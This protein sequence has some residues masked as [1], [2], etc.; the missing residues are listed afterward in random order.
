MQSVLDT[1][2]NYRDD[3]SVKSYETYAYHPITGTKLDNPGQIVIRIENQDAFFLP[4][5]SWLQVEW[6]L[7]TTAGAAYVAGTLISLT[8]NGLMFLFDNIKYE[9][10]EQEI[11]SIYATTMLRMA[12]Y[13][14]NNLN[15]CWVLDT[16][17]TS[18][19]ANLGFKSRRNFLLEDADPKGSF[20]FTIPLDHIFGFCYDYDKI[21]YGFVHTLTL[22]RSASSN[23]AIFRNNTDATHKAVDGKITINKIAWMMPKIEPNIEQKNKLYK[24]ILNKDTL[25]VGFRMRK[26]T[27]VSLQ[28]GIKEFTW[29][30]GVRSVPE[31]PRFMMFGFQKSKVGDQKKNTPLFD[32]CNL[33]NM[34]ILLNNVRYPAID[35][36]AD[37]DKDHYENLYKNLH[38]FRSIYYVIDSL[39]SNTNVDSSVYKSLFPLFAFDVSKQSERLNHGV[40][41]IIVEMNFGGTLQRVHLF[42]LYLFLIENSSLSDGTKMNVIY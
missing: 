6:Q 14:E 39:V 15:Q 3:D 36:H 13:S 34:Y 17:T 21:V 9:L 7:V 30:L 26:C 11:E 10:T 25:S 1:K 19:D 42:T 41:D 27:S 20:R 23:N 18:T 40:V 24:S 32:H 33:T 12:K 16:D 8:N 22:V 28:S 38:D 37:F 29:R 2:E 4:K 35:F 31:K 5:Q